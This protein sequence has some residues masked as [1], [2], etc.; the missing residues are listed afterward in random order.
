VS[1]NQAYTIYYLLSNEYPSRPITDGQ[2]SALAVGN[3]AITN[4]STG[5]YHYRIPLT[6]V[7]ILLVSLALI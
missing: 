7:L 6:C 4:P 1:S 3:S 2:V 5:K